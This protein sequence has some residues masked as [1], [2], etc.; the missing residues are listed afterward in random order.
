LGLDSVFPALDLIDDLAILKSISFCLGVTLFVLVCV[1]P[2]VTP[3]V[4]G[5]LLD[6][7]K[8]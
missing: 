2:M 5:M 3:V 7:K 4:G 1:T 6:G 8:P